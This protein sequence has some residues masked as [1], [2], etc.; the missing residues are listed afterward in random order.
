MALP[1]WLLLAPRP[2]TPPLA[3]RIKVYDKRIEKLGHEKYG[4]TELLRQVK[5]VGSL[6][7]L[8]YVLTLENP[9][10][11][12]KSRDVGSY[13]GLA[14]KQEDSGHS[15]PRLAISKTGDSMLRRG[16]VKSMGARR[17]KCSSASF[18]K[19]VEEALPAEVREALLPLV[20]LAEELS[21]AGARCVFDGADASD[22]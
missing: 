17:P 4:H 8:A 12:G 16:L 18:P 10:R 9:D 13:L 20:R 6:T 1:G 21:A 15:Q 22:Q 11:F 14:P 3:D 2:A 7:S 5:V 19:K